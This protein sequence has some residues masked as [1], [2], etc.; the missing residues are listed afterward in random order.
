M[1]SYVQYMIHFVTLSFQWIQEASGPMTLRCYIKLHA[2]DKY[3][4]TDKPVLVI[5]QHQI[6]LSTAGG[7]DI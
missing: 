3:K 1:Q 4:I 6:Q 5:Y 7:V 2:D